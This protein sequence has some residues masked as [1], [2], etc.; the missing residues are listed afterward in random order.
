[1]QM[2]KIAWCVGLFISILISSCCMDPPPEEPQI[3]LYY[4]LINGDSGNVLTN[5]TYPQI[6]SS[7]PINNRNDTNFMMIRTESSTI[8]FIKRAHKTDTLV[9]S[10]PIKYT[11]FKETKCDDEHVGEEIDRDL[12]VLS[13]T[14]DSVSVSRIDQSSGTPY[15]IFYRVT[16]K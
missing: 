10:Q 1:M 11:H 16:V 13:Y 12:N 6:G 3:S 7:I 8:L 15:A 2:S 5:I 14:F 4:Q 9:L